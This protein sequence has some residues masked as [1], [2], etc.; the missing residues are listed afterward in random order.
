MIDSLFAMAKLI[1]SNSK[2]IHDLG[3]VKLGLFGSYVRNE[4]TPES[5]LDFLVEFDPI[6]KNFDNYFALAELL[7]G[8]FEKHVDLLT[9]ESLSPYI[10]PH[11]LK[12][13]QYFEIPA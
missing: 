9:I 7:E 1:G 12:E 10:G 6:K 3:V 11:I 13:V 4:Q 2:K 5:D 8:I